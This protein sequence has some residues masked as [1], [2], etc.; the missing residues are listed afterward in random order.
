MSTS[1]ITV[2]AG[3]APAVSAPPKT[4]SPATMHPATTPPGAASPVNAAP[5]AAPPVVNPPPAVNAPPAVNPPLA[6]NAPLAVVPPPHPALAQLPSIDLAELTERAAL[7]TR[8]DRKYLLPLDEVATILDQLEA[9]TRVLTIDDIHCFGYESVYFD[10]PGLT[11]YRLTAQRRRRRFKVRTRVYLDSGECW[12]EVKTQGP[13]GSTVKSRL[14]Y[15][16][17]D[18][19]NL[20]PGR[21]FIDDVLT[22]QSI[23]CPATDPFLPTLVT[24]YRRSTLFLPCTDSRVTIDTDLSWEYEGSSLRLPEFAVVETKTGSTASRV[25]R[26][27]WAAGHR[28]LRISKY[29]TGLAALRPDLPSAPWRRTLR[30]HFACLQGAAGVGPVGS[31]PHEPLATRRRPQAA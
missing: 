26:L 30:Q 28:P 1:P 19:T 3:S 11:S 6:V 29:A 10:T 14:P 16:L 23:V 24:R 20:D 5:S 13:R 4:T 8:V 7:Q 18:R 12:L 2:R 22:E 27:L 15:Q 21:G 17:D 9:D 31:T 25:D